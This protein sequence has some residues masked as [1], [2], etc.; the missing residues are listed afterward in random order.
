MVTEKK[1]LI[2][3]LPFE[4]RWRSVAEGLTLIQNLIRSVADEDLHARE[5][6]YRRARTYIEN[7][8]ITAHYHLSKSFGF[9]SRIVGEVQEKSLKTVW[10][11]A[12]EL[13]RNIFGNDAVEFA[14]QTLDKESQH[15]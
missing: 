2:L 5:E 15:N 6:G 9:I 8:D 10:E 11:D 12:L 7:Q 4:I 13:E 1:S 14:L 3:E